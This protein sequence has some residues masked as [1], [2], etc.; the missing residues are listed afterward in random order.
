MSP[1]LRTLSKVVRSAVREAPEQGPLACSSP[2]TY[3]R[4]AELAQDLDVVCVRFFAL[5]F[6]PAPLSPDNKQQKCPRVVV[7]TSLMGCAIY[8]LRRWR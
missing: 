7:G 4:L 6:S 1:P 5:R 8:S 3:H 2:T